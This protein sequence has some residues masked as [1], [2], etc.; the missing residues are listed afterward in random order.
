VISLA[1]RIACVVGVVGAPLTGKGLFARQWIA[2]PFDGVRLVWSPVE[3]SDRY[4][5]LLDCS[6]Y[7]TVPA[8]VDGV[9][10]G[11]RNLV[12]VPSLDA[13]AMA[14]EFDQFCRVVPELG[15]VRVVVE[16]LSRVTKPGWSPLSWKNLSLAGS[17][18]NVEVL[19]TAQS[20]VNMDK[21]FLR[22]CTELRVYRANLESDARTLAGHGIAKVVE[23]MALEDRQYFHL[24]RSPR[25]VER[26]YQLA[27]GERARKSAPK[28]E[29][30]SKGR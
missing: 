9:L 3:H 11:K 1:K 4:A 29:P 25:R 21:D 23:L 26:G 18:V 14:I 6:T 2:R 13:E 15:G 10:A 24:W 16:E 17:H 27:P 22:G 19:G 8:L 5:P 7:H 30:K 28:I 20:T 12:F